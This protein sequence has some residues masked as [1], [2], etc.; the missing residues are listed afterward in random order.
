MKIVTTGWA[1]AV[2][3][4]LPVLAHAHPGHGPEDGIAHGLVHAQWLLVGLG[5]LAV[6]ALLRRARSQ[7]GAS[8]RS[9]TRKEAD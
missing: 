8:S 7:P 2:T 3:A 9:Q 6:V 4:L 5:C 1:V